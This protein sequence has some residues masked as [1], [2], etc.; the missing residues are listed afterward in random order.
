M[1]E[2]NIS[3]LIAKKLGDLHAAYPSESECGFFKRCHK[4]LKEL[5]DPELEKELYLLETEVR[6]NISTNE[7]RLCHCD[8]HYG[9]ILYDSSFNEVNFIDF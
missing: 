7:Y 6:E 3:T 1:A 9:N 2:A 4:F 8:V 5:D